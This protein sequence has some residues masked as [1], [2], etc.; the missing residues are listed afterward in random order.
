M[1][2]IRVILI[3]DN[4]P[5]CK[6]I[7]DIF[8]KVFFQTTVSFTFYSPQYLNLQEI[9]LLMP[10]FIFLHTE[11]QENGWVLSWTTLYFPTVQLY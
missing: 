9:N 4:I 2:A 11:E 3:S 8:Q 5:L 7:E 1:E 6:V 10:H